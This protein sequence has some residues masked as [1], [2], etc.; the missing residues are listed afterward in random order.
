MR[1]VLVGYFCFLALF[2]N[3]VEGSG[4]KKP[5]CI[6]CGAIAECD[7]DL[8]LK[9][10]PYCVKKHQ[11]AWRY[12]IEFTKNK[13]KHV[14]ESYEA[15]YTPLDFMIGITPRKPL[16]NYVEKIF[17]EF[18]NAVWFKLKGTDY[19]FKNPDL[20]ALFF[21]IFEELQ[22]EET[23]ESEQDFNKALQFY[24]ELKWI[25]LALFYECIT[26]EDYKQYL[27]SI[28]NEISEIIRFLLYQQ[29][30]ESH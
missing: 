25:C 18:A 13:H 19:S 16:E 29:S 10:C 17:I 8:N 22:E 11:G 3:I 21:A 23:L 20:Q 5:K 1:I 6:I 7:V 27:C 9:Y 2:V 15:Q 14:N 28:L 24:C 30:C 4:K 12:F 26:A